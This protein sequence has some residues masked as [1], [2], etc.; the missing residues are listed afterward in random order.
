MN[1][2]DVAPVEKPEEEIRPG[3]LVQI[4]AASFSEAKMTPIDLF[5]VGWPN[6]FLVLE[7]FD[8]EG[9]KCL[10]LDPCCE[11]MVNRATGAFLCRGHYTKYFEKVHEAVIREPKKGDRKTS[12]QLPFVGDVV[13]LD[14]QNEEENPTLLLQVKG[15]RGPIGLSGEKAREIA[16]WAKNAGI[17]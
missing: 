9:K 12:V 5:N 4:R 8:H 16:E 2:G 1:N 6:M 15:L 10:R 13:S 14:Y 3:D 11:W 7:A 17:L